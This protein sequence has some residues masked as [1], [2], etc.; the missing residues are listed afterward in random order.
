MKRLFLILTIVL[1]SF[2]ASAVTVKDL[3]KQKKQNLEKLAVTNRMLNET[4]KGEANSISRLAIL[5]EQIKMRQALVSNLNGEIK[6]IEEAAEE[7]AANAELEGNTEGGD[8]TEPTETATEEPAGDDIDLGSLDALESFSSHDGD[9]LLED[10]TGLEIL[11]EDD[12][13]SPAD[14]DSEKDFSENN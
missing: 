1:V 14:L 6:A 5:N 11:T 9:L 10:Q 3:Q 7:E 4:Q 13:P 12:L 8:T 2:L